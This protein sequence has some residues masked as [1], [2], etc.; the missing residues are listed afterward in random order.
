M[1]IKIK[2]KRLQCG[3]VKKVLTLLADKPIQF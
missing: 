3:K 2:E 1:I